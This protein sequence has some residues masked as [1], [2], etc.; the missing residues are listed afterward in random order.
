MVIT[1]FNISRYHPLIDCSVVSS[2]ILVGVTV[3]LSCAITLGILFFFT[4][5][6]DIEIYSSIS[7]W[8][9]SSIVSSEVKIIE[10]E[11]TLLK[12]IIETMLNIRY[13]ISLG[14]IIFP[15]SKDRAWIEA[16]LIEFG[17]KRDL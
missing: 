10:L 17:L 4:K 6:S 2:D 5:S 8:D 11:T 16:F 12:I 3:V 1:R 9:L 13:W 14:D 15:F 7:D